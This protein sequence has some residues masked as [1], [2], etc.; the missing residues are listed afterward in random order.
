MEIWAGL[1]GLL[2]LKGASD[3]VEERPH[4]PVTTLAALGLGKLPRQRQMHG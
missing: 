1:L 4:Q 2:A 3:E